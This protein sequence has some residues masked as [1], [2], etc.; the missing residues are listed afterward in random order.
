MCGR[1]CPR[2]RRAHLVLEVLM[3]KVVTAMEQ[4]SGLAKEVTSD[5]RHS[6]VIFALMNVHSVV[7]KLK[8]NLVF[9]S[10]AHQTR[11]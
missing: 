2:D 5:L 4:V 1:H 7:R 11:T 8:T 10:A 9:T 3:V 6:R